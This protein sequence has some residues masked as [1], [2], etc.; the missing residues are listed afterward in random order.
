MVQSNRPKPI[1]GMPAA[2]CTS[3][4]HPCSARAQTPVAEQSVAQE[5]VSSDATTV[6]VTPDCLFIDGLLL[7]KGAA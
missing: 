2:G 3:I 1:K 6:T 4:V 7:A 5:R